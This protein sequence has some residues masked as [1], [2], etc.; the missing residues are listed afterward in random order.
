MINPRQWFPLWWIP[1]GSGLGTGFSPVA[2]GT[3]GSLVALLLWWLVQPYMAPWMQ[4]VLILVT[5]LLGI[6]LCTRME[7]RYGH[8]PAQATFDEFVGQWV[9]LLFLP[10]TLPFYLAAFII[11]RA[12]DVWKPFPARVS[13]NLPGGLGIMIDDLIVGIYTCLLLHG[14]HLLREYLI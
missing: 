2:S 7:T 9:A 3:A 10:R 13:Q 6:P 11:F 4:I 14:F 5:F 8:D 1:L 12:L